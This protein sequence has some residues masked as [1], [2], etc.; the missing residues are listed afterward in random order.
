MARFKERS[1]QK[2]SPKDALAVLTGLSGQRLVEREKHEKLAAPFQ[3][4]VAPSIGKW[5][6]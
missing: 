3:R 2:S 5:A 4:A 6:N 1:Q